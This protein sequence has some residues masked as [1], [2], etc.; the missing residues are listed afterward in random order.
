MK[1]LIFLSFAFVFCVVV[2]S[3][4]VIHRVPFVHE[5]VS[6]VSS[7]SLQ[8]YVYHLV[9]FK[10]RH[11]HSS[12]LVE[13][14]ELGAAQEWLSNKFKSYVAQSGGRLS[15][16]TDT[17]VLPPSQR[18]PFEQTYSNVVATIKGSDPNDTRIFLVMAHLDSRAENNNEPH[19]YS[20]GANDDGSGIAA[21]IELC[22]ILSVR[23]FPATIMLAGVSGEEVGLLGAA[24][25]A[26][27]ARN[28]EW[29]IAAVLNNDMIGQSH[30]NGIDIRDNTRMRVFSQSTPRNETPEERAYRMYNSMEND[31][32][33]RQLA[34]YI[35]TVAENYVDNLEVLLIYREDRFGRGG[36]QTP[37]LNQGFTAVRLMEMNEN[38][39]RQHKNITDDVSKY[40]DVPQAMDF[41]YLRKTTAVNLSVVASLASAPSEPQNARVRINNQDNRSLLSWTAPQFGQATGYYVLVRETSASQWQRKYFTTATEFILPYTR[42]NYFFGIQAVGADETESQ[43]TFVT[44]R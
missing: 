37:F 31:G 6:T 15:V 19:E 22:R 4:T 39:D 17:Y 20:P 38:F 41:E 21:L 14:N 27:K 40:G 34:R 35:K 43:I 3:Q 26:Q 10:S 36:D 5:M 12:L 13:D 32:K 9:T 29:N 18:F 16:S 24:A 2:S 7:D 25:M 30:G 42:D 11:S 33:S 44:A 8:S 28:E 23:S 1:K